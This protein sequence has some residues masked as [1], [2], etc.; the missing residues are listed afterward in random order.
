VFHLQYTVSDQQQKVIGNR[1]KGFRE[2]FPANKK[3]T[4]VYYKAHH[5]LFVDLAKQCAV[6]FFLELS[7]LHSRCSS[8]LSSF[9]WI[10]N[11]PPPKQNVIKTFL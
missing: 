2:A 9:H 3:K 1:A 7:Q 6:G 8:D 4:N 5:L 11:P 10:A